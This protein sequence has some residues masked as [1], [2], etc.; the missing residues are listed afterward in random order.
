MS[1][2]NL[3]FNNDKKKKESQG[4]TITLHISAKL[5]NDLESINQN[6]ARMQIVLKLG[7][8]HFTKDF[9]KTIKIR[10]TFNLIQNCNM[11]ITR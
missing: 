2:Y 4:Y 1:L 11:I 6:V 10:C 7:T 8:H 5:T 3:M 9:V